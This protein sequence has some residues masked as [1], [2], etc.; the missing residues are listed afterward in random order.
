MEEEK[1]VTSAAEFYAGEVASKV[2]TLPSG[3]T[4][5]IRKIHSREGMRA[6]SPAFFRMARSISKAQPTA[7]KIDETWA[8][9]TDDKK[10]QIIEINDNLILTAV[11][12]PKISKERTAGS[13]YL[14]DISDADYYAMV[15]EI[16]RYSLGGGAQNM[17]PFR[18]D[19]MADSAGSAGEKV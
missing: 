7:E 9:M 16:T 15:T 17:R 18:N 1:K 13:I 5:R 14:D 10:A 3:L 19:P 12:E 6:D 4:I 2:L 11:L 8:S